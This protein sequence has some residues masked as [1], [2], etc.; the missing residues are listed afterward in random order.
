MP[1]AFLTGATGFL[2]QH[3]V[4]V[5][6]E[7]GWDIIALV[8]DPEAARRK[9]DDRISLVA[10]DIVDINAI[11]TAM[12]EEVDCVF[13]A[14][15]D[16]SL[17]SPQHRHQYEINVIGTANM[18]HAA[19]DRSA[20]RFVHISSIAVYGDHHDMLSETS[21]RK[22]R[23]AATN[24]ART[25][26]AAERRVKE[27]AARGLNAV[28][29][30]PCHIV[31]RY[32]AHNWA[33][34]ILQVEEGTLP[35]I[36]P[37]YGCF[38]NGRKVAEA[39]ERAARQGAAGDTFILGGPYAGFDDFISEAAHQLSKEVTVKKTPAV[40]LRAMAW[41]LAIPAFFTGKKPIITHEEVAMVCEKINASSTK[42]VATLGYEE[43]PLA[44][45]IE[46]CIAWLREEK[47]LTP[48]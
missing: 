11:R 39:T 21:E 23:E 29:L 40:V 34:L 6:L 44:T 2:G 37:G 25:K 5:L 4:G 24:Y 12:P 38:S 1:T 27:A 8:R 15:A 48:G 7:Q 17:W 32:D 41:I 43:V 22:G 36:P 19:T 3:L 18:V 30:N 14:A 16:T 13:H 26:A 10:G 20:K 33:R 46:E 47:Q 35:G 31:G 9:F 45:S 28:I 42:A